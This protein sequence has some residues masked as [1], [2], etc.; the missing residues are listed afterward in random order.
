MGRSRGARI[1]RDGRSGPRAELARCRGDDRLPAMH[2]PSARDSVRALLGSLTLARPRAGSENRTTS[3]ANQCPPAVISAWHV[4]QSFAMRN[5]PAG[6][7]GLEPYGTARQCC[8]SLIARQR[9]R[10]AAAH[11]FGATNFNSTLNAARY[12]WLPRRAK[13]SRRG[14]DLY[15]SVA[16]A[17]EIGVEGPDAGQPVLRM[18]AA[19][20]LMV[21]SNAALTRSSCCARIRRS[22]SICTRLIGST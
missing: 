8:R 22:S 19:T 17:C 3:W 2:P 21:T 6:P 13:T 7:V 1:Q 4:L 9:W 5:A 12:A 18:P 11:A 20:P 15:Q 14:P 16:H 10:S